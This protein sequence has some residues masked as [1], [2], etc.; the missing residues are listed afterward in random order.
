[1]LKARPNQTM[2]NRSMNTNGSTSAASAISAPSVLS[3]LR[4]I[5]LIFTKLQIPRFPTPSGK[6]GRLGTPVAWDDNSYTELRIT[7]RKLQ[8]PH[9]SA[10]PIKQHRKRHGHAE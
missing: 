9:R 7:N 10:H 6:C 5:G 2:P 8:I 1:M 3:S 4:A